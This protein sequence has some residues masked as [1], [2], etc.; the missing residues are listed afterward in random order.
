MVDIFIMV[1]FMFL[2]SSRGF[3]S[4][5]NLRRVAPEKPTMMKTVIRNWSFGNGILH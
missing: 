4:F 1:I 2:E 5:W 3:S